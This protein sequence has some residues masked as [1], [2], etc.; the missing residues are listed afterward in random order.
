MFYESKV[1]PCQCDFQLLGSRPVLKFGIIAPLGQD[2][3]VHLVDFHEVPV[4]ARS[5]LQP[6]KVLSSGS[7]PVGHQPLFPVLYSIIH[8]TKEVLNQHWSLGPR[9]PQ[10]LC[11]AV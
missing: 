7:S 9:L 3:A 4:R 5:F 10:K 1:L 2:L 6:V 11:A 8:I